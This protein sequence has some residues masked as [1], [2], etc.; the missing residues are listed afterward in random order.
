M[1]SSLAGLSVRK[2][3]VVALAAL[4]VLLVAI[5]VAM[6]VSRTGRLADSSILQATSS[7]DETRLRRFIEAHPEDWR[8]NEV[9][10]HGQS[11]LHLA[12]LDRENRHGILRILLDARLSPN[13][14]D[15]IGEKSPLH[16]AVAQG[17]VA[18]VVLL[19]SHG[20]DVNL[21]DKYGR[22]PLHESVL[23]RNVELCRLL[24]RSGANPHLVDKHGGTPLSNA[25]TMGADDIKEVLSR[26]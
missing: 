17:D 2:S 13:V 19:I 25:A 23:S 14:R 3:H 1:H 22:S 4:I 15:R 11:A 12:V 7:R 20:A 26:P 18:S 9:D 10:Q 6:R 16:L 5:S 21:P 24:V 8:L